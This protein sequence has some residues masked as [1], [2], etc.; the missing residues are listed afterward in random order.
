MGMGGVG[1]FMLDGMGLGSCVGVGGR[2]VWVGMEGSVHLRVM[3]LGC[4]DLAGWGRA[5]VLG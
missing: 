2:C 3:G 1:V 5:R 4:R